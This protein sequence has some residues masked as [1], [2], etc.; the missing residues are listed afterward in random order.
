[1][2]AMHAT[3]HQEG[4]WARPICDL[5]GVG[6]VWLCLSGNSP[7]HCSE[8]A[9]KSAGVCGGRLALACRRNKAR[10]LSVSLSRPARK[11]VI[12]RQKV[13]RGRRMHRLSHR[14]ERSLQ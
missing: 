1:M 14:G 5:R 12:G 10:G 3:S 7:A 13:D 4:P 9:L 11:A 6:G 2:K 8:H